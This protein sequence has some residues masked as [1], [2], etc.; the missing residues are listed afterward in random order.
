MTKRLKKT[1]KK[2]TNKNNT[3][4]NKQLF[5]SGGASKVT[6]DEINKCNNFCGPTY[7]KEYEKKFRKTL[8]TNPYIKPQTD[9]EIDV[10]WKNANKDMI[11]AECK[12]IYCNPKCVENGK[13]TGSLRYVCPACEKTFP[14]AKKLGAITF[15][16]GDETLR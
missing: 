9:A 10:L 6:D 5:R 8:K 4:R 14:K 16:K 13:N 1:N 12:K 3:R 2:R 11:T 7:L 15:C